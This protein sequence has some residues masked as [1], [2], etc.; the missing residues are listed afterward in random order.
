MIDHFKQFWKTSNFKLCLKENFDIDKNLG[1]IQLEWNEV[2]N[3]DDRELLIEILNSPFLFDK[4]I[5]KLKNTVS[6][7]PNSP[8]KKLFDCKTFENNRFINFDKNKIILQ[9][10][11]FPVSL[12]KDIINYV[13]KLLAFDVKSFIRKVIN[14]NKPKFS[15]GVPQCFS[16]KVKILKRKE[17]PESIFEEVYNNKNWEFIAIFSPTHG[18]D[19]HKKLK[20]VLETLASFQNRSFNNKG[21]IVEENENKQ[22]SYIV[23]STENSNWDFNTLEQRNKY[24]RTFNSASKSMM[25]NFQVSRR[26]TYTAKFKNKFEDLE[27]ELPELKGI[28]TET[29]I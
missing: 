24:A 6:I 1:I 23:K 3:K 20:K 21:I 11:N 2:N 13:I 12:E 16:F 8:I 9:V 28:F 7:N 29:N 15:N 19:D 17:S 4:A 14:W 10:N 18:T 22:W 25:Q 5:Y 27:K 26:V